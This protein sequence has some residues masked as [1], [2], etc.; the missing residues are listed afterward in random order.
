LNGMVT[1][2]YQLFPNVA[3]S[4][5]SKHSTVTIFEPLSPTRTLMLIYR[6]TNKTS[7]GMTTNIEEAKRD[8]SFVKDAGFDEDREAACAIQG[9][10][11]TQA[12]QHLTFGHFEKAIVHFHQNLEKHLSN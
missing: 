3:V 11:D 7:D 2:V 8:A 10:L 4:V 1:S 12:N 9:T 5:L 6:A